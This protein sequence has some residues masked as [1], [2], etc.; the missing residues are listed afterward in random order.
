MLST[1]QTN[2]PGIMSQLNNET[3]QPQDRHSLTKEF[4]EYKDVIPIN[5]LKHCVT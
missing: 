1:Y 4:N 3:Q 2:I 5:K